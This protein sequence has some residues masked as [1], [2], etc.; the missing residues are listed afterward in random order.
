ML[1]RM[2]MRTIIGMAASLHLA[3]LGCLHAAPPAEAPVDVFSR[4]EDGYPQ[5]R[6]PALVV[7]ANGTLLA[8]AE[9]RQAG[10]HSENDIVLKCS[11]DGGKTWGPLQ[12]VAEMG[13]DSLNDPCAVV[14]AESGRILLMFQRYPQGFHSRRM[15]HTEM[16]EKGYGGPR[17][18]QTFM[19]HSDDHGASW[20]DPRDVTRSIRRQDAISVGSPGTGIEL[21]RRPHKGRILMPLYETL[22][23]GDSDRYWR[24]AVAISDDQG[25]SWRISERVP[26][27]NLAGWGNE[28]Q[29]V[30]L[31]DG[32][33]LLNARN[34]AGKPCRK[35]AISRDAGETWG[36]MREDEDL[37]TVACMGSI[38]R[39]A[40]AKRGE[41]RLV[42]SLPNS[43]TGRRNGAAFMSDDGG[44]TWPIKRTIYP[45][46]FAYS[47]LAVL[48]DGRLACLFERDGYAHISFVVL[49]A[50]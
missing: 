13:G 44:R 43:T 50:A 48:P 49:E 46:G 2:H 37:V 18:T 31:A 4:G 20:S 16:V 41:Y 21:S 10:D 15:D 12:V 35:S 11:L 19:V 24:N 23:L 33:I 28:C 3:C 42:V 32:S 25:A 40:T 1:R 7:S 47:C 38:V 34:Q 26:H 30:E 5:V 6:I 17:N 9:G 39:C 45:R 29:L 14:L 36:P 8:F 27:E 22:P